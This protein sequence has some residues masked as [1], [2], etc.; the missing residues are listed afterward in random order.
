MAKAPKTK[1]EGGM[2]PALAKWM[3][4]KKLFTLTGKGSEG[5]R[6]EVEVIPIGNYGID[7]VL[8]GAGGVPRGRITEA[9]GQA[10]A[11]KSTLVFHTIASAQKAGLACFYVDAEHASTR[12]HMQSIGID[13]GKLGFEQP[14]TAEA[15]MDVCL[16]A[17]KSGLFGLVVIDSIAAASPEAELEGEMGDFQMGLMARLVG[18]W[19]RKVTAIASST[20]TAVIAV[21]Q[22]RL[23]PNVRFGSPYQTTG[24][25]ALKFFASLRLDCSRWKTLPGGRGHVMGVTCVKNKLGP[26]L[27]KMGVDLVYGIGLDNASTLLDLAIANDVALVERTKQWW[28]V[29]GEPAN[30]RAAACTLVRGRQDMQDSLVQALDALKASGDLECPGKPE[31]GG[32]NVADKPEAE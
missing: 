19:C 9:F 24:G 22:L 30:G 15:S 8:I 29:C 4:S 32:S 16:D 31:E 7:H 12:S 5:N 11:G 18:Q 27:K 23:R 1:D 21:N 20:N 10:G 3:E 28:T 17:V 25:E 6:G 26:P 13:T 14:M 2:S